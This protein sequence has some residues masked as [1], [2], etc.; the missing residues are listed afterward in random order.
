MAVEI[1][2][3]VSLGREAVKN[4]GRLTNG[5]DRAML[6]DDGAVA[7]DP[8]VGV[9]GDDNGVVKYSYS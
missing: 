4:I 6:D 7:E 3:V 1:D 2:N 9:H 8:V 5:C